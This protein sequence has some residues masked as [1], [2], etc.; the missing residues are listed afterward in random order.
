MVG[1]RLGK[2]RLELMTVSLACLVGLYLFMGPWQVREYS[3]R[4]RRALFFVY[5]AADGLICC[6]VEPQLLP[7][8]LGL[9]ESKHGAGERLTN[10]VTAFGQAWMNLGM[11]GGPFV[12][13]P[14]VEVSGFRGALAAWASPLALVVA[15]ALLLRCS[16]CNCYDCFFVAR[17]RAPKRLCEEGAA[18]PADAKVASSM[19]SHGETETGLVEV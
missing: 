5:L 3:L 9:A 2:R 11:V 17:A 1:D 13:V 10:L 4:W 12:A 16:Y 18:A 19:H 14:I 7:H 15:W 6:L 8:M